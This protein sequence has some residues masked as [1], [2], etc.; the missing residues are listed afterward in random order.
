MTFS[1]RIF[2]DQE[3]GKIESIVREHQQQFL[4]AW[5]EYFGPQSG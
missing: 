5:H 1:F 4:E 2:S 3:L